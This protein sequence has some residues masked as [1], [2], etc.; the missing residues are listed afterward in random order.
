M[1]ALPPQPALE[2]LAAFIQV[3]GEDMPVRHR[4]RAASGVA[5]M[6]ELPA[7]ALVPTLWRMLFPEIQPGDEAGTEQT[8]LDLLLL[9][10]PGEAREE[11]EGALYAIG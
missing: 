4:I 2:Q 1:L 9:E 7:C 6:V 11:L 3:C 8:F 10:F 5:K